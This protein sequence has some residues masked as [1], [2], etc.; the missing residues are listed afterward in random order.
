MLSQERYDPVVDLIK[1]LAPEHCDFGTCVADVVPKCCLQ[2]RIE[3]AFGRN[4]LALELYHCQRAVA[5]NDGE[6]PLV[7][8]RRDPLE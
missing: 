4:P 6:R 1:A 3:S 8:R 5:N 2:L 7:G